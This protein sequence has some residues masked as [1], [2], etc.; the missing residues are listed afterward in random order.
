LAARIGLVILLFLLLTTIVDTEGW[1]R[2]LSTGCRGSCFCWFD[3]GQSPFRHR[4]RGAEVGRPSGHPL[5]AHEIVFAKL[6][7]GLAGLAP[8]RSC[9]RVLGRVRGSCTG[10]RSAV[11]SDMVSLAQVVPRVRPGAAASPPCPQPG[12]AF[13][14]AFGIVIGGLFV[15]PVL[16][17]MLQSFAVFS[18]DREFAERIVGWTNPAMYMAHVSGPLA[19][20]YRWDGSSSY[21]SSRELELWPMF[22]VYGGLYFGLIS[23]VVIWLI[24]RTAPPDGCSRPSVCTPV[25]TRVSFHVLYIPA[26]RLLFPPE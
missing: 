8:W 3:R 26:R 4:A 9:W 19:R 11:C 22:L 13:S 7:A 16:L 23:A 6:F 25:H 21:Q 20:S 12:V 1:W 10:S 17:L 14:S 2:V 24:R 18:S 15:F 5:T